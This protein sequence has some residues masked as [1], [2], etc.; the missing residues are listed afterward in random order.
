MNDQVQQP[1]EQAVE[2]P[3]DSWNA[4]FAAL[5]QE[6]RTKELFAPD[7]LFILQRATVE[8]QH[9]INTLLFTHE[10]KVNEEGEQ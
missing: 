7:V 4:Q 6:A 9:N 2:Q 10:H 8:I 1:V 5:M 3:I